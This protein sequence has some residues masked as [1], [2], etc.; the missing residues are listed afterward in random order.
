MNADLANQTFGF[1]GWNSSVRELKTEF[2]DEKSGK[3]YVGVS[4][5]I[6]VELKN[7]CYREV[8]GGAG[9]A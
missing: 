1:D 4:A 2:C 6:R 7:G 5:L 8:W 3:W 9:L